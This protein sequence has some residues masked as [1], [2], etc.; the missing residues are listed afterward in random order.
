MTKAPELQLSPGDRHRLDFLAMVLRMTE[1]QVLSY[2]VMKAHVQAVKSVP[3][4]IDPKSSTFMDGP[5][6]P[7]RAAA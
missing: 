1:R 2:L 3:Y 7:E 4:N 5:L 6:L